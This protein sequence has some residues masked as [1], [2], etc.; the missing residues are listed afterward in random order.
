MGFDIGSAYQHARTAEPA[1]WHE[2]SR[3]SV[4]RVRGRPIRSSNA[5][6]R[7]RVERRAPRSST[8]EPSHTP[9]CVSG[10]ALYDGVRGITVFRGKL[11]RTRLAWMVAGVLAAALSIAVFVAFRSSSS[12]ASPR[13]SPFSDFLRDVQADRVK[14]VVADADAVRFERPR[15]RAVRDHGSAGLHRAESHLPVPG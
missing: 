2:V 9:T 8:T 5:R 12:R 7:R 10:Q 6:Y 13:P 1:S 15:W 14:S 4:Y 11:P 3:F